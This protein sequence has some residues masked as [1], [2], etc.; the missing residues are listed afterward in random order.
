MM[1]NAKQWEDAG[2]STLCMNLLR[3]IKDSKIKICE[4]IDTVKH[5]KMLT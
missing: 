5:R 3:N 2:F 4:A 1:N